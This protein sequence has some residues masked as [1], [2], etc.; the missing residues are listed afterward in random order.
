MKSKLLN[1]KV[2][3]VPVISCGLFSTAMSVAFL[4]L[5]PKHSKKLYNVAE[6][7]CSVCFHDVNGTAACRGVHDMGG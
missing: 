7:Q 6:I 5:Q 1:L 2:C 3:F 4:R